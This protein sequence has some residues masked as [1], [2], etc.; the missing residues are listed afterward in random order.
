MGCEGRI[1]AVVAGVSGIA[2]SSMFSETTVHRTRWWCPQGVPRACGPRDVTVTHGISSDRSSERSSVG[3]V[4]DVCIICRFPFTTCYR[5][6]PRHCPRRGFAFAQGPAHRSASHP[7]LDW[8]GANHLR[9]HA[10]RGRPHP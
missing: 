7:R 8:A 1:A 5:L 9:R 2:V 6:R 10:E 3:E 4:A